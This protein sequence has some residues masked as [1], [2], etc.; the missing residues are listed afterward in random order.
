M[1]RRDFLSSIAAAYGIT[2]VPLTV[3][4]DGHADY[5]AVAEQINEAAKPTRTLTLPISLLDAEDAVVV[6]APVAFTVYEEPG[7]VLRLV[8][9]ERG[10]VT[11]EAVPPGRA[12]H[13]I[14]CDIH[15]P[16][17][18]IV[19]RLRFPWYGGPIYT[20]GGNITVQDLKVTLA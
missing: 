1:N 8:G 5:V 2:L 9:K 3:L 17:R 18:Q 6:T 10:G 11:W 13:Q 15:L 7:D 14:V 20:N 12:I 19:K 4:P 16:E